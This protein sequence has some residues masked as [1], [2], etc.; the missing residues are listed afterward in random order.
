MIVSVTGHADNFDLVFTLCKDGRWAV[1]V[2]PDLSD[3]MY[4]CDI[5]AV[6]HNGEVAYW[7]GILYM[8]DGACVKFDLV[9]DDI[10]AW[11]LPE[12]DVDLSLIDERFEAVLIRRRC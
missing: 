10:T 11:L 9:E 1:T 3:G 12:R 4:I 6:N 5:Y 7:T 2:P 8:A